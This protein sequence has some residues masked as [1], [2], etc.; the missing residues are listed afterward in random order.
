VLAGTLPNARRHLM[1]G[2]GHA[3]HM[4][5]PDDYVSVVRNFLL[6]Q[7]PEL[8]DGGSGRALSVGS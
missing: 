5:H 2:A 4:T 3:P 7:H 6:E 1:P 8:P